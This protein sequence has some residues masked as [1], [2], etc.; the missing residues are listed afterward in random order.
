MIIFLEMSRPR[1][2]DIF[3]AQRTLIPVYG[4]AINRE[5]FYKKENW[6]EVTCT[7]TQSG[8]E[9][10]SVRFADGTTSEEI[11]QHLRNHQ[12]EIFRDVKVIGRVE[13]DQIPAS[14]YK[15]PISSSH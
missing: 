6:Q 14:R 3:T 9:V 12:V 13:P 10:S 15:F 4:P 1:L 11:V 8:W 5:E 2:F 7:V